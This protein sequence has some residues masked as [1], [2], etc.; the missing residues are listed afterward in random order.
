MKKLLIIDN[1]FFNRLINVEYFVSAFAE[2][3]KTDNYKQLFGQDSKIVYINNNDTKYDE[4]Y[5]TN[6]Y[7][8]I[9]NNLSE[10]NLNE[11][12]LVIYANIPFFVI[13][14]MIFE[15]ISN[16]KLDSNKIYSQEGYN[17]F[18]KNINN[19]KRFLYSKAKVNQI[20]NISNLLLYI[21]KPE[22]I[23]NFNEEKT[24]L[25]E[26]Q[27]QLLR[28]LHKNNPQV[29]IEFINTG[30]FENSNLFLNEDEYINLCYDNLDEVDTLGN[31]VV[32]FNNENENFKIKDFSKFLENISKDN[33]KCNF[34][35]KSTLDINDYFSEKIEEDESGELRVVSNYEGDISK[36]NISAKDSMYYDTGMVNGVINLDDL[37]VRFLMT[38]TNPKYIKIYNKSYKP[39]YKISKLDLENAKS[40]GLKRTMGLGDSLLA[41]VFAFKIFKQYN[42][43]VNFYSMYNFQKHLEI[44]FIDKFYYVDGSSIYKDINNGEDIFID[45]D[46]AYEHLLDNSKPSFYDCY[47]QLFED[48]ALD[49]D[50]RNDKILKTYDNDENIVVCN[51]E[52]S[53]WSSKEVNIGLADSVSKYLKDKNYTVAEMGR[54]NISHYAQITNPEENLDLLFETIGKAKY[55]VGM[56]SG[57]L[58]IANLMG[59]KCFSICGS[60]ESMK[61]Q[62]NLDNLYVVGNRS[63]LCFGCR[64]S[65]KGSRTLSDGSNTFVT[66]CYNEKQYQCMTELKLEDIVNDLENFLIKYDLD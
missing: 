32:S 36:I 57:Q 26:N 33:P 39:I 55:Y 24:I 28:L 13:N 1:K 37:S 38:G 61:T 60:A 19:Q 25:V 51:W 30:T 3:L 20:C 48:D 47:K 40:I 45:F 62:F 52:G 11:F 29:I 31:Y 2:N 35:I 59:K 54:N 10:V 6:E 44:D 58:H 56:D 22:N 21:F 16:Q 8:E 50:N 23:N 43:K 49:F 14:N 34:E 17:L 9:K 63:L 65:Y 66:P 46:L 53:G 27:E 4:K 12:D 5:K 7:I 15:Q 42:K 18:F 41:S 64:N